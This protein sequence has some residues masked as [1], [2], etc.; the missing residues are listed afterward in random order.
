[1][2]LSFTVEAL[3]LTTIYRITSPTDVATNTIGTILGLLIANSVNFS[4]QQTPAS[5]KLSLRENRMAF[6]FLVA[7]VITVIGALAPFNFSLDAGIVGWKLNHFLRQP[8]QLSTNIRDELVVGFRFFLL[9]CSASLFFR[10]F[11]K[12]SYPWAGI[13]FAIGWAIALEC[14]QFIVTSRIPT[15]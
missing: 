5:L 7:L 13:T 15:F 2:T 11:D 10:S 8:F 1:M 9:G 4:I 12:R 3:Q 6:L 14:S